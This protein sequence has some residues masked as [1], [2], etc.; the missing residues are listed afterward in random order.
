MCGFTTWLLDATAGRHC[1]LGLLAAQPVARL[2][3][4]H[5]LSQVPDNENKQF[6]L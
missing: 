6:Q 2:T 3:A 1:I 4:G 5:V